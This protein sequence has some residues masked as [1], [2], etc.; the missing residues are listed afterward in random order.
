MQGY[1]TTH[2]VRFNPPKDKDY[3]SQTDPVPSDIDVAGLHPRRTGTERVIVSCKSWQGG[4]AALPH[5]RPVAR[6]GEESQA[7]QGT[8]VPRAVDARLQGDASEWSD[9]PT[10]RECLDGNPFRF[11]TLQGMWG[12][13]LRTV[14]TTPAASEMGSLGWLSTLPPDWP[15]ARPAGNG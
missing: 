3:V 5:P 8:A 13:V 1:F 4:F 10:I 11:L 9:D 6:R 14:T 7:C 2:S 12:V 15:V